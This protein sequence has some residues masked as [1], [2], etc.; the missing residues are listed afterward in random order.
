MV[1]NSVADFDSDK[2]LIRPD[3]QVLK[4]VLVV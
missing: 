2:L 1:P 3:V 4:G